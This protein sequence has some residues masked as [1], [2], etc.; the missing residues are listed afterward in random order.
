MLNR[1]TTSS[2]SP[3]MSLNGSCQ[4]WDLKIKS[5]SFDYAHRPTIRLRVMPM[6]GWNLFGGGPYLDIILLSSRRTLFKSRNSLFESRDEGIQI[7]REEGVSVYEQTSLYIYIISF[8][9]SNCIGVSFAAKF[10]LFF[11]CS[12]F[13]YVCPKNCKKTPMFPFL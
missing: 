6:Y 11:L 3:I 12:L 7:K 13:S 10:I 9:S 2:C 8:G 4:G 5:R 1:V